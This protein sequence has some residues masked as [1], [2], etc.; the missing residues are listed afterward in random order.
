L[1]LLGG[2][3]VAQIIWA[4]IIGAIAGV[5]A[6]WISPSPKNPQGFLLTIGLGIAGSEVAT[7]L[8]RLV[9]WYGPDQSAG[10]IASIVGAVIVL[11]VWHVIARFRQ[12]PA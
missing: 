11:A 6:R 2:G 12:T 10:L 9:H 4:L 3:Q 1:E 8:G 5:V 7:V